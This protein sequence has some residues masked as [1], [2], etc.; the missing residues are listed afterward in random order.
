MLDYVFQQFVTLIVKVENAA[1]QL[2]A[3]SVLMDFTSRIM[4]AVVCIT[5]IVLL[6]KLIYV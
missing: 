5:L 6:N 4:D 3:Q 1:V 2:A